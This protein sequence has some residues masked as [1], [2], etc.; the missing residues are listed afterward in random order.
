MLQKYKSSLK[1]NL[2]D[3]PMSCTSKKREIKLDIGKGKNDYSKYL[4]MK[5]KWCLLFH[6]RLDNCV[7]MDAF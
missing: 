7:G 2:N 4:K 1:K 6:N 3:K 5:R